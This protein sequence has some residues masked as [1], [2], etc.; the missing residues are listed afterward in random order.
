MA[1]ESGRRWHVDDSIDELGLL[2]VRACQI[3]TMELV[4]SQMVA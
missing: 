2:D 3:A 1:I 4:A